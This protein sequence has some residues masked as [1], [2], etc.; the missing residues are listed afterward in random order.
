MQKLKK[1]LKI[2]VEGPHEGIFPKPHDV[3]Y[4]LKQNNVFCLFYTLK[5]MACD[6]KLVG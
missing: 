2:K 3:C 4:K 1:T 5:V 6:A